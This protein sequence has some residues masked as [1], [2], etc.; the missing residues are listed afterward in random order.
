VSGAYWGVVELGV[1]VVLDG[2][3]LGAPFAGTEP[4]VACGVVVPVDSVVP[5]VAPPALAPVVVL[6]VDEALAL[7]PPAAK[8][9]PDHQSFE[10]RLL[11]EAFM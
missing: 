4:V 6:V 5:V 8:A 2:A 11:G 10:A 7:A 9:E 1:E 3:L